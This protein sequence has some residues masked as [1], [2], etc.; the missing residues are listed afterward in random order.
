MD[1]TCCSLD[2]F[3]CLKTGPKR[4]G[5]G[6]PLSPVACVIHFASTQQFWPRQRSLWFEVFSIGNLQSILRCSI[7][8]VQPLQSLLVSLYSTVTLTNPVSGIFPHPER[9]HSR[10]AQPLGSHAGVRLLNLPLSAAA[11]EQTAAAAPPSAQERRDAKVKY[12]LLLPYQ[13]S[14]F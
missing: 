9:R 12:E 6:S 3:L 4:D 11:A 8:N 1:H 7:Y 2:L 13:T 10:P 14:T 5:V